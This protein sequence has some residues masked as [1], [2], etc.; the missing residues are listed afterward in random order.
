MKRIISYMKM[1]SKLYILGIIVLVSGLTLELYSPI[2][3]G[4]LIDDVIIAGRTDIFLTLILMLV[5]ITVGRAIFG[6]VKEMA[7]DVAGVNVTKQ[8]RQDLFDHIQSLSQNYFEEKNTGELMT[9]LKDDGDKV[10]QGISFGIMLVIE[11]CIIFVVAMILMLRI[12]WQLALITFSVIPFIGYF[13][14]KLEKEIDAIYGKISEKNA[15]LNTTAQENI[16]GVRLVKAFAREKHEVE[17]FLKQNEGYYELNM[18]YAKS[19]A[20]RYPNIE[21]LSNIIPIFAIVIGG[22][23][24]IG[25]GMSLGTLAVFL[26][27]SYMIVWPMRLIG[28]LSSLMAE[29]KGGMKK[30]D[31][32]F[33]QKPEIYDADDAHELAC[34]KGHVAFE[35]VS[36]TFGDACIL[37]DINF[38]IEPGKTMAIMG[39]TGSGKTSIINLLERFYDPTEGSVRIDG[40]DIKKLTLKSLRSHIAVIMQELFLFS[41]T[42]VNNI[43]FGNEQVI[44]MDNIQA[45][46]NA[47]DAHDFVHRMENKYET[48]IGERGIGLS[49][50]QKQRISIARAFAKEAR[51]LVMDD[52][53]SALDMETEYQI[54]KEIN[55]LKGVTKVIIAH[56]ISAVKEAD[57][58][59]IL[60]NGEI[61]ERGTHKALLELKGRYFKTFE[62]QYEGYS[63][64]GGIKWQ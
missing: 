30:I 45:A 17:K 39:A 64:V 29:A 23:F 24:V 55:R 6:Y 32:V 58:I 28:W 59:I 56:R 14:Y 34:C 54:Q 43:H 8:L 4:R 53:T 60:E 26:G 19:M 27:Y 1:N 5:G 12:N 25:D 42:I 11:M 9:R 50:G 3:T 47:A 33:N 52:A 44:S 51:I 61:V 46:A 36:L 38:S 41:D 20:R 63:E 16:A 15:E 40:K 2:I 49:G 48:V 35:H 31:K 21:M 37:K 57:E 18:A 7:F 22:F 13:A 62:E 10:W